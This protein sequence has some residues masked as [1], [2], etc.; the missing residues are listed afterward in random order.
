MNITRSSFDVLISR[1]LRQQRG[2]HHPSFHASRR[3]V[4]CSGVGA[5]DTVLVAGATGGVGQ[6][7]CA[8]LLQRGYSVRALVRNSDK[9]AAVLGQKEGLE[10]RVADLRSSTGLQDAVSGVDAVCWA[11]GTTAFPSSRWRGGNGPEA[12][13]FQ[14]FKN[15]LAALPPSVKRLVHVSSSGVERQDKFPYVILNLFGVF[16]FKRKAEQLLESSGIPWVVLRPGRLTDGPYTSYDINTVLQ[17]TSG[18]RQD[19]QLSTADD[20]SGEASRIA[21]AEAMVQLL[22]A[23][24]VE[25]RKF[26]LTSQEG[27]GPQQD[28][29]KWKALFDKA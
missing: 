19:V 5:K 1:K 12:T 7:L 18:S 8:N 20:Q 13:D 17:A 25:G 22:S 14:A 10:I 16:K 24:G 2:S 29:S 6:L 27:T 11:V 21:I 28:S 15:L 26:S 23:D 9:A 4:V 3:V